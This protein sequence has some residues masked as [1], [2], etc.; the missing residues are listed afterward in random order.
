MAS[1]PFATHGS[2][3]AGLIL[4]AVTTVPITS[5]A[6]S[7]SG[8]QAAA[9]DS[10][11][12]SAYP[13]LPRREGLPPK[14]TLNIPN[15]QIDVETVPEVNKKLFR[16]AFALPGV[17]NRPT[18]LSVPGVRGLWLNDKISL[19]HPEIIRR[20]REFAHIHVD[21]SLHIA[22]PAER[23]REAVRARW[24]FP[25]PMSN[26]EGWEGFVLL[27]TPQ[28]MEELDWTFQLIVDAYNYITGWTVRAQDFRQK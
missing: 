7:E 18:I 6:G 15:R 4:V 17:E 13:I 8:S 5:A 23:A 26:Q 20:G 2:L 25:H 9:L 10:E 24:A 1:N 16:R 12:A 11:T 19:V 27:Y 21:G 14:V 22:L 28:S 3:V